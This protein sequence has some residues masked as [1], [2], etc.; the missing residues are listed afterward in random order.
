MITSPLCVR[1][2]HIPDPP[3]FL[4]DYPDEFILIKFEKKQKKFH[5]GS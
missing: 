2:L 5:S 3:G 1:H 4:F